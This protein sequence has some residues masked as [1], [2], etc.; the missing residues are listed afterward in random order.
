M[1]TKNITITKTVFIAVLMWFFFYNAF[2]AL[3]QFIGNLTK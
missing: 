3:G 1:K 2:Y